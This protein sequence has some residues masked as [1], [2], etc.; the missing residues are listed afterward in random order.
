[1]PLPIDAIRGRHWGPL[2]VECHFLLSQTGHPRAQQRRMVYEY[3]FAA[4]IG[5]DKPKL[6]RL[7]HF[8]GAMAIVP[9]CL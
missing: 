4:A 7:N 1:M 5:C 6:S 9:I 8:N 2:R 3:I